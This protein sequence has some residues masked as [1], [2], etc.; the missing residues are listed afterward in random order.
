M[1]I[2]GKEGKGGER[3]V[4]DMLKALISLLKCSLGLCSSIGQDDF[5][6]YPPLL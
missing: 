4:E 1:F 6:V 5:P 3:D 2:V